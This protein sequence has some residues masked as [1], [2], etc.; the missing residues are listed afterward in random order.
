[1]S[2]LTTELEKFTSGFLR[3]KGKSDYMRIQLDEILYTK[4]EEFYTLNKTVEQFLIGLQQRAECVINEIEIQV[5]EVSPIEATRS[6]IREDFLQK[7]NESGNKSILPAFTAMYTQIYDAFY[8]SYG[9]KAHNR[10]EGLSFTNSSSPL[11]RDCAADMV[12]VLGSLIRLSESI[13]SFL[14]LCS[15]VPVGL[16]VRSEFKAPKWALQMSNLADYY[17]WSRS[18]TIKLDVEEDAELGYDDEV[19]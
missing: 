14:R 18:L 5:D 9:N 12:K 3:E 16:E 15:N 19:N 7:L 11:Y 1:M 17:D 10:L 8:Y 2:H 13:S 4:G 6:Y